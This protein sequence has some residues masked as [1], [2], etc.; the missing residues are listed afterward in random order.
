MSRFSR[1]DLL[2][3]TAAGVLV[4]CQSGWLRALAGPAVADPQR[5]RACILL[6]MN[7]G[8][9]QM[10]TFDLK[11]GHENGGPFQETATSVTGIRICEH[12]PSVAKQMD[13][14]AIVRSMT[15][16]EG[17]HG[18]AT[19]FL[20]T[21]YVPTGPVRYPPLG[22]LVAQQISRD[23]SSLPGF[24]SIA[25]MRTLSPSALGPG[26]LGPRYAPLMVGDSAGNSA[27]AT[28]DD[29]GSALTVQ[30]LRPS[31][32]IGPEQM[33]TRV[34]MLRELQQEF[35]TN[36]RDAPPLAHQAA[37]EGAVKLMGPA[38]RRAF[39][40][41]EES[42]GLRNAYGQSLFGQGCLLARR[43]VERGVPFVEVTLGSSVDGT[44]GW[45]THYDNFDAVKRLSGVLDPAWSTLM[46]DLKERGLID[47]TLVVWMGEFG[48]TPKIN[49]LKGRDHYPAAWSAVLAGGGIKGGQVVGKTS[50]DGTTVEDRPVSAPDL[51]ATI[52]LALGIDPMISNKSN[53]G[54]PIHIVEKTARPVREVLA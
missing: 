39:D 41:K 54:R 46:S 26:F 25:P 15:S 42:A 12:L 9:S 5:R 24:V 34:G 53:V 45:D 6:W 10:D 36:H 29:P 33:D 30:N 47:S 35:L 21:G 2:R 37:I 40:L 22:S 16:K 27:Q 4:P 38:A 48:R 44:S 51:L 7:G 28:G 52:C 43:L 49:Q 11:P 20:K 3:L 13:R 1:R 23:D 32:G 17:D 31:T 19:F 18:R 14:M 50:A 8:P